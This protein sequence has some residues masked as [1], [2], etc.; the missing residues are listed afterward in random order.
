MV[1]GSDKMLPIW[2]VEDAVGQ[3]RAQETYANPAVVDLFF[4]TLFCLISQFHFDRSTFRFYLSSLSLSIECIAHTPPHIGSYLLDRMD[5]HRRLLRPGSVC[6]V[7]HEPVP[8][9]G[10][11]KEWLAVPRRTPSHVVRALTH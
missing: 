10:P 9:A 2:A 1:M 3:D 6:G 7:T 8:P 5:R 11:E 4:L